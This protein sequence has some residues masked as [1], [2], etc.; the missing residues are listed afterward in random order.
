MRVQLQRQTA[1]D[2]LAAGLPVQLRERTNIS[3]SKT[4]ATG[5]IYSVSRE[6]HSIIW[7]G[8]IVVPEKIRCGGFVAKG[9]RVSVRI[10]RFG[11]TFHKGLGVLTRLSRTVWC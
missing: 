9:I 6:A 11:A 4:I 1:I 5:I 3:A 7:S 2:V 10:S 8:H